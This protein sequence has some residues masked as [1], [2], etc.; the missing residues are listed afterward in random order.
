[1]VSLVETAD[2]RA[3]FSIEPLAP[4][5][6]VPSYA[7]G[8]F[9]LPLPVETK[10]YTIETL[11]PGRASVAAEGGTLYTATK[12]TGRRGEVTL[13]LEVVKK[14]TKAGT[15]NV[16]GVYRAVLVPVGAGKSGE[17]VVDV[18]FN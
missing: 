12:T 17:V 13:T 2:G 4:V 14:N 18:T 5:G 3:L 11:G 6:G 10:T 7:P 9:E 15:W 1:V 16:H 8:V